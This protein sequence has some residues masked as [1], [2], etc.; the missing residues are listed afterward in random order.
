MT[1]ARTWRVTTNS[2]PS[3]ASARATAISRNSASATRPANPKSVVSVSGTTR[4]RSRSLRTG[5]P[6]ATRDT[7]ARLP[8]NKK[9]LPMPSRTAARASRASP[10]PPSCDASDAAASRLSRLAA[11]VDDSDC[12][13]LPVKKRS[14][15]ASK[16]LVLR[17]VV[18]GRVVTSSTAPST[19]FTSANGTCSFPGASKGTKDRRIATVAGAGSDA[20]SRVAGV[21]RR[22]ASSTRCP[23]ICPWLR[24]S[25]EAA[26]ARDVP[27][28]APSSAAGR[29]AR[30]FAR[31]ASGRS[32]ENVA[33]AARTS[34]SSV[35]VNGFERVSDGTTRFSS[36]GSSET[37]TPP[38][39]AV[40][41]LLAIL[42]RARRSRIF[43][44]ASSGS[45]T[46]HG[47]RTRSVTRR[48]QKMRDLT[49]LIKKRSAHKSIT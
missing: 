18:F 33:G 19:F 14:T 4:E 23:R 6:R 32:R 16:R 44:L 42:S 30:W 11:R 22:S 15:A 2:T 35:N 41:L 7:P 43:A 46:A 49:S 10:K 24:S 17:S 47:A 40:R 38:A 5:H 29:A 37:P 48:V 25:V 34:S 9:A 26:N 39:R 45:M 1:S 8:K 3:G 13:S 31:S 36:V 27:S 21:V 28:V 12:F 20:A